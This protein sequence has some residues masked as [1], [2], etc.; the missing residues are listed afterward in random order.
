VEALERLIDGW[1]AGLPPL[2][3]FILPGGSQAAALCHLARSLVRR[4]ERRAVALARSTPVNPE[5]LRYLNRLSD[6]LFVMARVL[7]HQAG[8]PDAVWEPERGA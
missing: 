5:I 1:E 8:I 2:R 6:C 7:N 3:A 4:A